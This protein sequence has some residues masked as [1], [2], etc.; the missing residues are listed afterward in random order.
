[1]RKFVLRQT[2]NLALAGVTAVPV[3]FR[4]IG[5]FERSQ[6]WWD[7]E[8]NV[9]WG[10]RMWKENFRMTKPTFEYICRQLEPVLAAQPAVPNVPVAYSLPVAKRVAIALHKLGSC[11]EYRIVANQIGVSKSTATVCVYSVC[12]A[13]CTLLGPR[14]LYMPNEQEAKEIA[15]QFEAQYKIPQV[16]GAIDGSHIPI[17][18]PAVGRT[19]FKNRKMWC[20]WVLQAVVDNL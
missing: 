17:L 7:R 6:D 9:L 3:R 16:L 5:R 4:S 14:H 8:V 13:V 2:Q 15:R 19:D 1:M 18:P 10:E 11:S 12:K 20:S